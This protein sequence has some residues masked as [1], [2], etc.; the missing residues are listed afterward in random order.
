ME[1][2]VRSGAAAAE[3][4]LGALGRPRDHLPALHEEAA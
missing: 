3:A 2:A 4:A 1:G